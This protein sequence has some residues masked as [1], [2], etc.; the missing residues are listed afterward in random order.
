MLEVLIEEWVTR[1]EQHNL[2]AVLVCKKWRQQQCQ[3]CKISGVLFMGAAVRGLRRCLTPQEWFA[4]VCVGLAA[5]VCVHVYVC[6]TLSDF[7]ANIGFVSPSTSRFV[8]P[9]CTVPPCIFTLCM[10]VTGQNDAMKIWWVVFYTA[11][12]Q[13]TSAPSCTVLCPLAS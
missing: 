4:G 1:G 8:P 3:G 6:M 10:P 11:E 5:C 9:S 12:A 7:F 13:T 2:R